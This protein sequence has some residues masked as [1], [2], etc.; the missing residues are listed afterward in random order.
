MLHNGI[1]GYSNEYGTI[2]TYPPL[3]FYGYIQSGTG[4]S[5]TFNPIKFQYNA[6][7]TATVAISLLDGVAGVGSTSLG[8]VLSIESDQVNINFGST[9]TIAS[10]P[11]SCQ[12]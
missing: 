11:T 1:I 5:L 2:S 6:Y 9:T 7:Q 3:G 10:F 4:W 12:D 8:D